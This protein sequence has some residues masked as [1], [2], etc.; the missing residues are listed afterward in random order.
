[1]KWGN[2]EKSWE[3]ERHGLV[4]R[5]VEFCDEVMKKRCGRRHG[6]SVCQRVDV[7]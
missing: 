3:V 1:M 5:G 4:G 2:W 7:V 6:R